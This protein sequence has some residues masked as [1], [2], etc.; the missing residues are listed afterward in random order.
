[1]K[2]LAVSICLYLSFTAYAQIPR[3]TLLIAP[4]IRY[5]QDKQTSTYPQNQE[6]ITKRLSID[7]VLG[8]GYFI[9]DNVM[10][11]FVVKQGT[12]HMEQRSGIIPNTIYKET[13]IYKSTTSSAGLFGRVYK[14]FSENKLGVFAELEGLYRAG[15]SRNTRLVE[16]GGDP[17]SKHEFRGELTGL[18]AAL[19]PGLVYFLRPKIALEASI[20]RFVYNWDVNQ[21]YENG[22]KGVKTVRSS[23]ES[24]INSI[25]FGLNIYL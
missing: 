21:I 9:K 5:A 11:G 24:Q 25:Y 3:G 23:F 22:Q 13:N 12:S 17:L 16:G 19:R 10:L 18:E 4:G 7:G 2:T 1:M 20:A 6:S 14:M 15:R 8:L